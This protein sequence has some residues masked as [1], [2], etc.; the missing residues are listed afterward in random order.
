MPDGSPADRGAVS[1]GPHPDL[2]DAAAM[3]MAEANRLDEYADG[4]CQTNI[5]KNE[6]E[7]E[8]QRRNVEFWTAEQDKARAKA[9]GLREA[10]RRV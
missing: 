7:L 5:D 3:L 4:Q 2:S 1:A 9:A 10:A 6:A 8:K